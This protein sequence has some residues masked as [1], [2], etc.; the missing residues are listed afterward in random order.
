[1]KDVAKVY[2]SVVEVS[3]PRLQEVMDVL[4]DKRCMKSYMLAAIQTFSD[5]YK[6]QEFFE[7][8][9]RAP[10]PLEKRKRVGRSRKT[11]DS[12]SLGVRTRSAAGSKPKSA[13]EMASQSLSPRKQL[14]GNE[15]HTADRKSVV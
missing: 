6:G 7:L 9:T 12:E 8:L 15:E 2:K 5:S 11:G 14:S 1:M 13:P 10:F 4:S 3:D